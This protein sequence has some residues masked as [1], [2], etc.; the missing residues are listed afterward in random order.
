MIQ[1]VSLAL[2]VIT[3]LCFEETMA[4]L[5]AGLE[6]H[7]IERFERYYRRRAVEYH[8]GDKVKDSMA[9]QVLSA[10]EE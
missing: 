10:Y 4:R 9:S 6:V 8:A 7:L 2:H 1:R 5:R 3:R